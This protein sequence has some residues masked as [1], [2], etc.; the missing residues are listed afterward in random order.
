MTERLRDALQNLVDVLDQIMAHPEY[1]RVFTIAHVHGGAYRGPNWA[2][3]LSEAK[4]ALK[5]GEGDA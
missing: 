3:A 1:H 2:E 5:E 4:A